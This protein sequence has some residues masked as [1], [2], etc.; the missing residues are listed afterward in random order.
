MRLYKPSDYDTVVAF[1][2]THGDRHILGIPKKCSRVRV[3]FIEEKDGQIVGYSA[4]SNDSKYSITVVH[5]D[6][7]GTG[8]ASLLMNAKIDWAKEHGFKYLDTKVGA[9]NHAS[10]GM[11]N[12]LGYVVVHL[13]RSITGK[14]V[15]TMRKE[16]EA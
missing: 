10:I 15:L 16:L 11:L 6:Y 9:T 14:P 7:R 13:G 5:R 1:I 2:T 3:G 8:I 4:M 12:K